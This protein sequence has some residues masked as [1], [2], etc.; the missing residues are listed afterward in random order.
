M[1]QLVAVQA[2]VWQ[3]VSGPLLSPFFSYFFFDLST[4]MRKVDNGEKKTN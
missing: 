1:L 3:D 2:V 4:P